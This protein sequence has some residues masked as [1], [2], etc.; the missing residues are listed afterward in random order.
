M[1]LAF[2]ELRKLNDTLS[3]LKDEGIIVDYRIILKLNMTANLYV[4]TNKLSTLEI[5]SIINKLQIAVDIELLS[6]E[7]YY[8]DEYYTTLFQNTKNLDFGLR[9]SL[10]NII[11]Y[12]EDVALKSCPIVSFYSYKGGVGRTTALAHFASY[13]S[14]A[15][16]KKVFIMDCDFKAPGLFNFFDIRNEELP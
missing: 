9:R 6:E 7:D 15:H 10:S 12:D 13:Y 5:N 16:F 2:E 14:I 8:L 11:E 1:L 3:Q 4:V